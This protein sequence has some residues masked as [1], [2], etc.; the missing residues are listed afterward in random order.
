MCPSAKNI[1]SGTDLLEFVSQL[2][3]FLAVLPRTY[4]ASVRHLYLIGIVI[5]L[6]NRVV[7]RPK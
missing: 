3:C 6:P 5:D 7:I 1:G 4:L 2:H